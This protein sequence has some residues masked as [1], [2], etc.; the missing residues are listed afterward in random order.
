VK[1][2]AQDRLTRG[3]QLIVHLVEEVTVQRGDRRN[4]GG[5]QGYRN[6]RQYRGNQ[7]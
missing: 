7:P 6:E 1:Q 3:A 5:A 4:P 2:S